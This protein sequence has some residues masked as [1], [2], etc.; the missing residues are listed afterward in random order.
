LNDKRNNGINI[1]SFSPKT[2][3]PLSNMIFSLQLSTNASSSNIILPTLAKY[4]KTIERKREREGE[5]KEG[6]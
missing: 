2:F 5:E 1:Y 4:I 6:E 3:C